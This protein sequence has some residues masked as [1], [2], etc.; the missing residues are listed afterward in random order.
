MI[1]P[2]G[3]LTGSFLEVEE[4][5]DRALLHFRS[6]GAAAI[7]KTFLRLRFPDVTFEEVRVLVSPHPRLGLHLRQHFQV[8]RRLTLQ[9]VHLVFRRT[10]HFVLP[11]YRIK[12]VE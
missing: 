8:R 9:H 2:G 11:R 1:E 7:A 10:N 4:K 12:I 5:E 6:A 3:Q